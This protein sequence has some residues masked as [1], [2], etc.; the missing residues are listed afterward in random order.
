MA[1]THTHSQK[2]W[3]HICSALFTLPTTEG[4]NSPHVVNI[5]AADTQ[6]PP[7][8]K[9][10]LDDSKDNNAFKEHACAHQSRARHLRANTFGAGKSGETANETKSNM[11]REHAHAHTHTGPRIVAALKRSWHITADQTHQ[12]PRASNLRRHICVHMRT[13]T[14]THTGN[15][16]SVHIQHRLARLAAQQHI[17]YKH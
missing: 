11:Q 8:H 3:R 14:R 7:A 6:T 1:Q 5:Q 17:R 16:Y 4:G 9:R 2:T 15:K 10:T 12:T 13:N